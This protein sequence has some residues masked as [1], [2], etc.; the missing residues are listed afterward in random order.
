MELVSVNKDGLLPHCEMFDQFIRSSFKENCKMCPCAPDT[1]MDTYTPTALGV[2][3]DDS[4]LDL[5]KYDW[6]WLAYV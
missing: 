5:R 6:R 4:M 2:N 1:E 3:G